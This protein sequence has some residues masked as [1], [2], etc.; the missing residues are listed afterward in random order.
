M[1]TQVLAFSGPDGTGKTSCANILSRILFSRNYDV[2]HVWIKISHGLAFLFVRL[3]EKIDSKH[4]IRSTSGTLITNS[5]SK[6][7]S[8]WLLIELSG[9]LVK[10]LVMRINLI[11]RR[12]ISR[13]PEIAIADRFLLDTIVHL[14]ISKILSDQENLLSHRIL[15]LLNHPVFKILRSILLKCS[16]TI[17][18][19]GQVTELIQRN[20]RARKA[21]PY[22]YMVLQKYLY[23]ISVKA[24]DIHYLYIDTSMKTL[25]EVCMEVLARLNGEKVI[26]Y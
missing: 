22:W 12:L 21:D 1:K 2:I 13:K 24:L 9:V 5:L 18:L 25:N 6:N 26:R 19:D 4:V 11:V 15:I 20:T 23:R 14:A 3:L 17:Y 16:F 7:T 10:I 8:M